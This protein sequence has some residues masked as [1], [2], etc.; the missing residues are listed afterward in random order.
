MNDPLGSAMASSASA[1]RAQ[2]QRIRAIS[3]N[4]ANA[5]TP[6]FRR[7][8]VI[9]E[10]AGRTE[11]AGVAVE[12]VVRDPAPLT[13]VHQP[14]HPS[15]DTEGYVL[16]SNVNPLLEVADFRQAQH[17]YDAALSMFEQARTLYQRTLDLLRR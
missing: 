12:R 1:M 15:A 6:G 8:Q 13:R 5:D 7:K 9:F 3:E 11:A 10:V 14:W 2:G 17:S 16:L 4:V